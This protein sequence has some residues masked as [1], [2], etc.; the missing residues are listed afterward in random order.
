MLIYFREII[1]LHFFFF[2]SLT[3]HNSVWRFSFPLCFFS[4][5]WPGFLLELDRSPRPFIIKVA[6][7]I[8]RKEVD[9][10]EIV[11]PS[12]TTNEWAIEKRGSTNHCLGT[13]IKSTVT[14]EDSLTYKAEAIIHHYKTSY[15][16]FYS[17]TQLFFFEKFP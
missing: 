8:T 7:C 4:W 17:T 5:K 15:T 1:F 9:G 6:G 16:T 2:F 12:L 14:H 10:M 13:K 11:L 3:R